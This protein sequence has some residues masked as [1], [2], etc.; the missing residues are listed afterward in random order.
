MLL[1]WDQKFFAYDGL[2][3]ALSFFLSEIVWGLM[4]DTVSYFGVFSFTDFSSFT[5]FYLD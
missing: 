5:S 3:F 2:S 4:I 1:T